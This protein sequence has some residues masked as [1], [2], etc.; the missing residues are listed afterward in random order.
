MAINKL[1]VVGAGFMGTGIAQSAAQNGIDAVAYDISKENL[2]RSRESL[3]KTLDKR[4][5]RNR[6]SEADKK[7]ILSLV[8]H[9]T[10]LGECKDADIVVE[11]V[12][13]NQDLKISILQDVE[14][15]ANPDATLATNTSSIS[16]T[17]IGSNLKD[18]SRFIGT[19]FFSPVPAMPLVEIVRGLQTGEKAKAVASELAASLGKQS[20][21]SRDEAGF[22]INRMLL[23]MLNEACF[24][25]ER[26]V[27]SIEEID[28]GMKLGLNHPMGPLELMDMIGIDVE[29]AVMEVLTSQ[30]G[31]QKYRPALTL[32]RM[33][34]AGYLG[35]KSGVGFYVYHD[36]GTRSPN[37]DLLK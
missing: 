37:V 24:L 36:D 11:A 34:D 25:V 9:T 33:V 12:S 35:R 28:E 8:H 21:H 10:D 15:A 13:E 29:L 30:T 6:I 4:V 17:T 7:D 23:P 22:L 1:F 32:R 3:T 19:H 14:K 20:I 27:G 16:I 26:R 31:D 5:K 18:P 2:E